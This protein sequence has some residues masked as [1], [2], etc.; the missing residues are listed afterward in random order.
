[1]EMVDLWSSD[2][3]VIRRRRRRCEWDSECMQENDSVSGESIVATEVLEW[4]ERVEEGHD[5]R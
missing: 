3:T 2:R 1:M 5:R 4:L